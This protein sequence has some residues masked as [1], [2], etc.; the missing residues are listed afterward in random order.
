MPSIVQLAACT[1][2]LRMV[3]AVVMV[4]EQTTWSPQ[5]IRF[6]G[7]NLHFLSSESSF[8]YL[9]THCQRGLRI[10]AVESLG[11]V[12][13]VNLKTTSNLSERFLE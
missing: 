1:Y 13:R 10:Q 6:Q 5:I 7:K 3:S 9:K 8:L 12:H 11:H 2:A 4:F